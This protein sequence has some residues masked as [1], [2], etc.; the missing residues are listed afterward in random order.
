MSM[1]KRNYYVS[2]IDVNLKLKKD[3]FI[4]NVSSEFKYKSDYLGDVLNL[5]WLD[6]IEKTCP[7]IDTIVR[8]AKFALVKETETVRMERSKNVTVDSIKDLVKH[9]NY[10]EKYDKSKNEVMPSK[11]L[12]VRSE[13]T[14]NIYE[15]RFLYTLI[16]CMDRFIYEKEQ[17]LKNL[18][19]NDERNLLYRGKSEVGSEVINIDLKITSVINNSNDVDKKIKEQIKDIFKRIKRVKEYISSWHKSEMYKA[20]EKAHISLIKPPIKKTNVILKNPNFQV[21]VLL[22]DYLRMYD[23]NNDENIRDNMNRDHND[24]IRFVDQ[25]FLKNYC[26]LDSISKLKTAQRHK[27]TDYLVLMLLD[28]INTTID[29]IKSCG[30]DITDEQLF[31]LLINENKKSKNNRLVGSDDVKK[32]FKSAMDEYLERTQDCL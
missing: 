14:F 6:E 5:D 26:V 31:N 32:K 25:A 29:M 16:D 2:D 8:K 15:N 21:A 27:M 24:L 7:N 12:N 20:L 17:K 18:T 9:T 1:S 13:E 4:E 23:L 10:I 3:K 19:V 11:I 30:Y 28:E 22:W